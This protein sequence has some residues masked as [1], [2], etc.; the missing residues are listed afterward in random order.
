MSRGLSNTLS[1]ATA[2]PD[3]N[4]FMLVELD[5]PDGIVRATSL[6][7]DINLEG[8]IWHGLSVLGS[9]SAIEEGAENRSYG[10]QVSLQGIPNEFAEYIASQEVQGRTARVLLGFL[11]SAEEI[12]GDPV[13]L[14]RARMDTVDLQVG[15]HTTVVIAVEDARLD[16]ERPR[17][18]RF[19]HLDQQQL[20]PGDLGLQYVSRA[21]DQQIV[22]QPDA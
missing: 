16:W 8:H 17:L 5:F 7:F 1:T 10:A 9:V 13:V 21:T 6:P 14:L 22:W 20:F 19:T 18:K 15:E 11:N 2:L 12:I 4:P 3:V